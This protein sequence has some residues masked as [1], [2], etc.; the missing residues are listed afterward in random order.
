MATKVQGYCH[1]KFERVRD[2]FAGNFEDGSDIGASF[3]M[4][5]D[6]EFVVDVW[7]GHLDE[8]KQKP[9][10]EDTIVN[11]YSTTK[12]MAAVCALVLADRGD[13]DLYA[14]VARYWPEFAQNGKADIEVRHFM[15]H[16]AGLS[17]LDGPLAAAD[18]YDWEKMTGLLAAQAPWWKPGSQSGYHA[19]TQGYLIGEVV[20]RVTGSTLGTFFREEIAEPLDAD[21]HI[22][23]DPRHFGR[24]GDLI[25]PPSGTAPM[26]TDTDPNSIAARTFRCPPVNALDSRTTAWRRAEIPAAN[27]HGNA[28]SVVRVQSLIANGGS[29]FG[30]QILSKRGCDRAFDE[31]SS[32]MDLVLGT[33]IRFGMGYGL[34]SEA[35]P[36]GPNPHTCFWGGW[37][38]SLVIVDAD[39]RV[40]LS[41]VMNKMGLGTTGD[42]RGGNLAMAAFASLA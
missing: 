41:Y 38:G 6:G 32:G 18:I 35:F 39:A 33:P 11:V 9:W 40:C 22:G 29:V 15:S 20:R 17:G 8:D 36:L 13:I 3:A 16:S 27:G 14:P 12:T 23:L 4:T 37:G 26:V 30:K 28:R 10:Q 42:A 5:V 34:T 1:D 19:I 21:F 7:G 25:P 31:Q 2:V 24:V